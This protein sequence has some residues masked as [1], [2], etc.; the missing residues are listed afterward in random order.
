MSRVRTHAAAG[1]TEHEL[2]GRVGEYAV[3]LEAVA[4]LAGGECGVVHVLGEP[5]IGK[6][7]LLRAALDEADVSCLRGV[8]DPMGQRQPFGVLLDALAGD[9][10]HRFTD[11]IAELARSGAADHVVGLAIVEEIRGRLSRGPLVVVIDEL[12]WA[13]PATL[14][15]LPRLIGRFR[16]MPLLL[17]T[18]GHRQLMPDAWRLMSGLSSA[19][20]TLELNLGPLRSS[21]CAV[22][23][24]PLLGRAPSEEDEEVLATAGGNPLLLQ[25]VARTM[26]A[27]VALPTLADAAAPRSRS[28][29]SLPISD[30]PHLAVLSADCLH[31]MTLASILRPGFDVHQLAAVSGLAT[32]EFL[33]RVREAVTWG[34]LD[35]DSDG[36]LR[37]R[38][39]VIQTSLRADLPASVRSELHRCVAVQL[40]DCGA[41]AQRVAQHL[42]QA[43][44]TAHDFEWVNSVATRCSGTAPD[45][46]LRLWGS[47]LQH[48]MPDPTDPR[49]IEI[50]TNIA[51]CEFSAGHVRRAET[52][53]RSLLES[54]K[55]NGQLS[56]LR[57]CLGQSLLLQGRWMDARA[58]AETSA[59]SDD[60]RPW[61]RAEQAALAGVAALLSGD[62]EGALDTAR[63]AEHAAV[64]SGSGRALI[65]VLS[66]RG[67]LA[68]LRG[69][70]LEA[71]ALLREAARLSRLDRTREVQ[72][73]Y[74]HALFAMVL[75]DLDRA[76]D[77]RAAFSEGTRLARESGS[78][79]AVRV[80]QMIQAWVALNQGTLDAAR[81]T[82][83]E[84]ISRSDE[85]VALWQ[86][87]QLGRRALVAFQ[88][89]GP[90][91]ADVWLRQVRSGQ[92][93][94]DG[95]YG[96]AW[97]PRAS[98]AVRRAR[99]DAKGALAELWRAWQDITAAGVIV[100]YPVLALDLAEVA[101]QSGDV[102]KAHVVAECL[103]QLAK[104]SPDVVSLE[105]AALTCQGLAE[106]DA[107]ILVAAAAAGRR[108]PRL[109]AAARAS[110]HAALAVART[111]DRSSAQELGRNALSGYA[112]AAASFEAARARAALRR[113][114]LRIR[115]S[116]PSRPRSGWESLTPAEEVIA[117]LV[118]Q[119]MTNSEIARQRVVSRRTVETHVSHILSKLEL[120]S[121]SDLIL[122]AARLGRIPTQ[123]E[124]ALERWTS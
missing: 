97:L 73:V 120:R 123:R 117:R 55:A 17:V 114:G 95:G 82:L 14:R 44:L 3:L 66:T 65:W 72:E 25:M 113:A 12:H 32:P 33:P 106:D 93:E 15:L 84:E 88:R 29:M 121:R 110:E 58:L 27:R 64:A 36:L 18:A 34:L 78:V 47:Y 62:V 70:L 56:A 118:V 7:A 69:E 98:A 90:D 43:A 10:R 51:L 23:A 71:E 35:E 103:A 30:L 63:R 61:E 38:H 24:E 119:G 57:T 41:P 104:L 52:M 87:R 96:M 31:L 94:G 37:F 20:F 116:E 89:K 86:P 111:S 26:R 109:V 108:S 50:E 101:I 91:A 85:V 76:D 81:R 107:E 22:L 102:E 28:A 40:D 48:S 75:A 59:L 115:D 2:V 39:P 6:S 49:R 79:T 53:A 99:G 105:V 4:D 5:G 45:V 11:G 83:D 77:A 112:N 19:G 9:E 46:A 54:G 60:L 92:P 42:L 74:A 21:D 124:P 8:A 100:D 1:R 16:S 122:A 67:H 13:D 68:H 80:T